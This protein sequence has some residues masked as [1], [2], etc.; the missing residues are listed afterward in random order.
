VPGL[1]PVPGRDSPFGKRWSL[2]LNEINT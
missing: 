1:D 2:E